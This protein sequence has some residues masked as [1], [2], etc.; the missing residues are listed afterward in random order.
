MSLESLLHGTP[1]S[2]RADTPSGQIIG[3][4]SILCTKQVKHIE[5]STIGMRRKNQ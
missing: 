2:S 4:I 1:G 5:I 3:L